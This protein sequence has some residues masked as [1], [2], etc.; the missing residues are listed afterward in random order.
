MNILFNEFILM[1]T[2]TMHLYLPHT[3][4]YMFM[5]MYTLVNFANHKN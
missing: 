5:S 3:V 1:V 2:V 4:L